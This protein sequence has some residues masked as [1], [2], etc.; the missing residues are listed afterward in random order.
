MVPG[1]IRQQQR[2]PLQKL[3]RWRRGV[4]AGYGNTGQQ[5]RWPGGGRSLQNLDPPRGGID[6]DGPFGLIRRMAT[7]AATMAADTAAIEHRV[8]VRSVPMVVRSHTSIHA[9]R[10]PDAH[11]T[12]TAVPAAGVR[13]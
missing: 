2:A 11:A 10:P 4:Q 1:G 3:V 7:A 13:R 8:V 9:G 12:T 6:A 5:G